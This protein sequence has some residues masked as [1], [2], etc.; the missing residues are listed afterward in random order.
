MKHTLVITY[1][2][3]LEQL[4]HLTTNR[5]EED[6]ALL[7]TILQRF[8]SQGIVAPAL[9]VNNGDADNTGDPPRESEENRGETT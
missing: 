2:D 9:R 8:I 1:D 5:F 3:E 4:V 7:Y 6:P